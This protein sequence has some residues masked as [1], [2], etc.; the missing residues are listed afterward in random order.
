MFD[1]YMRLV[2]EL[3]TEKVLPLSL[4]S[5]FGKIDYDN[6]LIFSNWTRRLF[7]CLRSAQSES[8]TKSSQAQTH[9]ADKRI[10]TH[11]HSPP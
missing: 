7:F 3:Q 8:E 6:R 11:R 2:L 10:G 4:V 9:Y 1:T 5:P